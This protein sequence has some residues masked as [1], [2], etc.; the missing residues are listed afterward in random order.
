MAVSER[1]W[2]MIRNMIR[3]AGATRLVLARVDDE[4]KMQSHQ[5]RGLDG[6]ILEDVEYFQPYGFTSHPPEN[7]EMVGLPVGGDRGHMLALAASDRAERKNGLKV[8]EVAIYHQNGDSFSLNEG[9]EARLSTQKSLV[10]ASESAAVKS[11]QIA[12]KGALDVTAEDGSG[13]TTMRL[14]GDLTVDGDLEVA[15]SIRAGGDITAGGVSLR[16]HV[17]GG[18]QSGGD[19]S[20]P[21]V[22]G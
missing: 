11:P 14:K 5:A 4:K 20:G 9:N 2:A 21:P 10:E 6:E 16:G 1:E 8:A 17:H 22:G 13:S 18:V 15:G 7:S 12:L 19:Q 3:N